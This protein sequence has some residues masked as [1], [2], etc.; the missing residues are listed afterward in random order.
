MVCVCAIHELCIILS[1]Y[2]C[3]ERQYTHSLV[4][5]SRPFQLW[6]QAINFRD[7]RGRVCMEHIIALGFLKFNK[8]ASFR[9]MTL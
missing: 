5:G 3:T 9:N 2:A 1:Y 6:T 7:R 8:L 4:D